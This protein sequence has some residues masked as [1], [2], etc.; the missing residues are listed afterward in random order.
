[1]ANKEQTINFDELEV[2][3]GEPKFIEEIRRNEDGTVKAYV[4]KRNP[5]YKKQ[6]V[7]S[8]QLAT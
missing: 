5:K 4:L 2:K 1:M 8:Y 3:M 7:K 6:I